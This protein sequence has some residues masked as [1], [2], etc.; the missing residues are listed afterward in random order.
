MECGAEFLGYAVVDP[1][2]V[3]PLDGIHRQTLQQNRKVE[4]IASGQARLARIPQDITLSHSLP[5][6]N[7]YG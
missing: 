7:C 4:V 5:F 1:M 3:P 6:F 2:A